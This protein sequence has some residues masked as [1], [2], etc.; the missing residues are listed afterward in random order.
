[1]KF[2]HKRILKNFIL[3]LKQFKKIKNYSI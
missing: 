2:L 1:M 3:V